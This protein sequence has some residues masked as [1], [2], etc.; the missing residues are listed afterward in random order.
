MSPFRV[1]LND[2]ILCMRRIPDLIADA[3]TK[4]VGQEVT[5]DNVTVLADG[6][7]VSMY[8]NRHYARLSPS[9]DLSPTVAELK[10]CLFAQDGSP[11]LTLE[12]YTALATAEHGD[13]EQVGGRIE[14]FELEAMLTRFAG[15]SDT[16]SGLVTLGSLP[17]EGIETPLRQL[18]V[19]F[20]VKPAWAR[21]RYGFVETKAD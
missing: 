2:K 3:K 1:P 4:V 5:F 17:S 21:H 6:G 7:G 8:D 16:D 14:G 9:V 13:C 19:A 20:A 15:L 18:L 12:A 11:P 10:Q